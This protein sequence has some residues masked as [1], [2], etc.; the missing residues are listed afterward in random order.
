MTDDESRD[1]LST[2]ASTPAASTPTSA[3][4]PR[5]AATVSAEPLSLAALRDRAEIGD[6]ISRLGSCLDEHRFDDLRSLFVEDAS[7][8]TQGGV[9]TGRDAVVAQA[10][11]NHGEFEKLQH[12]IANVLIDLDGDRAEV[13]ANM[14]AALVRTGL[15]PD[16]AFGGVY[17]FGLVRTAA[18]W[19][20]ARL[21]VRQVWRAEE[22]TALQPAA[23]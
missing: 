3:S 20:F 6:L 10:T 15:R 9:A 17:T 8:S 21:A 19:R 2:S 12:T 18:G 1:T 4:T 14:I 5:T 13:R 7:A 22:A 23:S 16:L 11:R